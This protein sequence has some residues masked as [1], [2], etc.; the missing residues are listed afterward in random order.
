MFRAVHHE[1]RGCHRLRTVLVRISVERVEIAKPVLSRLAVLGN[2]GL[3]FDR[4]LNDRR[5]GV[6][7]PAPCHGSNRLA[8]AGS[9]RD[10]DD[11]V[12]VTNLLMMA[13]LGDDL[14]ARR[15]ITKRQATVDEVVD[16]DFGKI[17][18]MSRGS[19]VVPF[20]AQV[21]GEGLIDRH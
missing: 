21:L 9:Y 1:K 2:N 16:D 3:Q 12:V 8:G 14:P 5:L 6:A 19:G 17:V 4:D 7:Y 18:A 20:G 11:P 10:V 15:A 13:K